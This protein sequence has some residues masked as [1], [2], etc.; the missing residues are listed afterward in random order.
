M[1]RS[2]LHAVL[3]FNGL[4]LLNSFLSAQS[5]PPQRSVWDGFAFG[6]K[7][8]VESHR[9]E[10][11][12]ARF[13]IDVVRSSHS[14]QS[15]QVQSLLLRAEQA[16]CMERFMQLAEKYL[17]E[18][19]SPYYNEKI[20]SVFLEYVVH[21]KSGYERYKNHHASIAKNQV[22]SCAADFCFT[23]QNGEKGNL[24]DVKGKFVVLF[25]YDPSCDEC[26]QVKR[27]L[28]NSRFAHQVV[29][30]AVYIDHDVELWRKSDCPTSWHNVYA[31][32][33]DGKALY[34]IRALPTLYL[35]DEQKRVLLKDASVER[36]VRYLE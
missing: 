32:D 18:P 5:L 34:S 14:E 33:I 27:V 4:F 20:Y 31:P 26:K 29:I 3:L 28:V 15:E 6:N 25:F 17:Y 22:G 1:K 16:G 24:Y 12:F 7:E 10:E 13:L 36:L 9:A 35:L 23:Y 11:R 30:M 8:E 2:F 19:N 21:K